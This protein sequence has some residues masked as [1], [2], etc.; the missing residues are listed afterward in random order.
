[1]L[2]ALFF[3]VR[4]FLVWYFPIVVSSR[5]GAPIRLLWQHFLFLF[6]EGSHE[7]LPVLSLWPCAPIARIPLALVAHPTTAAHVILF[8]GHNE[9]LHQL[10]VQ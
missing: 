9:K 5:E 1:M 8:V 10:S 2:S 3:V 4:L 6:P 7:H